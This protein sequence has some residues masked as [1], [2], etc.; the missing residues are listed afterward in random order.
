MLEEAQVWRKIDQAKKA[1][2][3]YAD[4]LLEQAESGSQVR[5]EIKQ[6]KRSSDGKLTDKLVESLLFIPEKN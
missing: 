5:V 4:F 6:L 2:K 3:R 1:V